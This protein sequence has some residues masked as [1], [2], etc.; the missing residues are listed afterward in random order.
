MPLQDR[1]LDFEDFSSDTEKLSAILKRVEVSIAL[2]KL[3]CEYY[4]SRKLA[5]LYPAV[6]S[7]VAIGIL[8]F[9]VTTDV[10]KAHMKIGGVTQVE[11]VL[12]LVVGFLGIFVGT[13][14]LLMN[15]WDFGGRESMHM[16][17]MIELDGLGNRVRYY[18]MDRRVGAGAGGMGGIGD[19]DSDNIEASYGVGRKR[20]KALGIVEAPDTRK[21]AL[22]VASGKKLEEM[23]TE[24][25]KRT[26]AAKKSETWRDDVTR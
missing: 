21:M 26:N 10:I 15:Q 11:D 18:K 12:T 23:E 14:M 8:G 4:R 3:S 2:H 24:I 22:I 6:L 13:V 20:K 1:Q 9:V 16:S 17:A 25:K 7:C 5:M 19:E